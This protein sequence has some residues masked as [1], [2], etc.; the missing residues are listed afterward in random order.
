MNNEWKI[1]KICQYGWKIV[2]MDENMIDECM[3]PQYYEPTV[4]VVFNV[5]ISTINF[6]IEYVEHLLKN[7][8]YTK[9]SKQCGF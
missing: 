3:N 1:D 4:Y 7:G 9:H 2:E 6:S 5:V 8:N